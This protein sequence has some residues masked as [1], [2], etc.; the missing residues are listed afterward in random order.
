MHASR[1]ETPVTVVDITSPGYNALKGSYF[2]G[3]T[4]ELKFKE[5]FDAWGGL[6]NPPDSGVNLYFDIFTITNFS[7]QSYL[8]QIWM[9][10][11]PPIHSRISDTV[12]PS[13]QSINP[14]PMPKVTL[15]FADEIQEPLRKGINIF[16]RIVTPESTLVSDSH[17]GSMIIGPGGTFSILLKAYGPQ[18]IT[19]TIVLTWWEERAW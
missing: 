12:T 15:L 4:G 16:D 11:K 5:G 19:G 9:N 18:T 1:K 13:N 2:I 7:E 8:A 10:A 3:Q 14:P 6:V 17:Q